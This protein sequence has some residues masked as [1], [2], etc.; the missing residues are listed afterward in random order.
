MSARITY[1]RQVLNDGDHVTGAR[2]NLDTATPLSP[3][4]LHFIK[5]GTPIPIVDFAQ[6]GR[7]ISVTFTKTPLLATMAFNADRF[8]NEFELPQITAKIDLPTTVQTQ[9]LVTYQQPTLINDFVDGIYQ[10]TTGQIAYYEYA[11]GT[12]LTKRPLVIFLHGSGERGFGNRLPLLANDIPATFHDYIQAHEDSVL[13]VPQASWAPELNG[14]FRPEIEEALR[15]LIHN[16]VVDEN[17]DITRIYLAGVSN[18]GAATWHLAEQSPEQ[19]AAI[20]P[21]CGYIYNANKDFIAQPGHGRYM[22]PTDEE[23]GHLKSTPIWAFHAEDDPTVNVLGTK[24]TI[25]TVRAHGNTL[26]KMTIFEKGQVTPNAHASWELAY[27][28][29][30][31]LPWL[32]AQHN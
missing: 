11:T 29:P 30:Q 6:E 16:V 1:V 8:V 17:I 12:K 15:N 24:E 32:F 28:N 14:W 31:L 20:I 10:D 21:C 26:C 27:D 25:S 5:D 18:G 22:T 4:D 3:A 19:F 23:A 7:E 9:F 13:L 2:I